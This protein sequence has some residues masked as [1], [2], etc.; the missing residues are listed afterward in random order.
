MMDG[1]LSTN[2]SAAPPPALNTGRRRGMMSV[3]ETRQRSAVFPSAPQRSLRGRKS[4]PM[5]D[6]DPPVARR[7]VR[8]RDLRV[9]V[10]GLPA[11]PGRFP[12]QRKKV[13]CVWFFFTV[14]YLL[15]SSPHRHTGGWRT[16][17]QYIYNNKSISRI[18]IIII[19]IICS[20]SEMMKTRMTMNV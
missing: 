9:A 14:S 11:A 5:S 15:L 2:G 8:R 6:G 13:E 17:L 18:I 3:P 20:C 10:K 19:F 12:F 4:F 16:F 7:D 1:S